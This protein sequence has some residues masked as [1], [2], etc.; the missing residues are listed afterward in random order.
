MKNKYE[1]FKQIIRECNY[2]NT[3]KMAWE[4]S[5]VELSSKYDLSKE[6]VVIK[7]EEISKKYIKYYWN[8]MIKLMKV[9]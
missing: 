1:L 9:Y 4:K 6:K 2:D 5:I 3:Y 7:F 8:Q